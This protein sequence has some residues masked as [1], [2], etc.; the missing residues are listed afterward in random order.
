MTEVEFHTGVSDVGTFAC[1]LLRKAARQG[2]RVQVT[3]PA[4]TL[5]ALDRQLWDFDER[6]FV[7]HARVPGASPEV[8]QRSP[9][10]LTSQR[11]GGDAPR[12]VVNLD[13]AAPANLGDLD[14]L[15]EVVSADV[16]QAERGRMRWRA[17]KAQGLSI[18]HHGEPG[19][20]RG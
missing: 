15:I 20:D 1:R 10:W 9:I 17:Y 4:E 16:D 12:V 7:P 8:L 14:R 6:D 18:K 11:M 5:D 13:E 3:A 19:L 2:V